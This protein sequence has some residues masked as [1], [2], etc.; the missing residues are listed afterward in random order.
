MKYPE[1]I[2]IYNA[3]KEEQRLYQLLVALNDRY[4]GIKKEILRLEPLP[5]VEV[6]YRILRREDTR[7][8]ILK[9][10][11]TG[12][13]QGVAAGLIARQPWMNQSTHQNPPHRSGG[14]G[15]GNWSRKTKEEKLKLTCTHCEKKKHSR[16]TCFELHGYPDWWEE[17]KSKPPIRGGRGI[18]VV[19]SGG[20]E[21]TATVGGNA[22]AATSRGNKT[23]EITL[24]TVSFTHGGNGMEAAEIEEGAERGYQDKE[25]YWTWH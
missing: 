13:T 4:E 24:G 11:D 9:T 14:T 15:G 16:D 12:A 2:D 18:V 22:E 5:S 10:G 20:R 8:N 17:R 3:G 7:A 6:A 23:E 19:A 21:P 1:D 25:N